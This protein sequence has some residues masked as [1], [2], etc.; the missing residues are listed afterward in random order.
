MGQGEYAAARVVRSH[1]HPDAW[2]SVFEDEL[3]VV[4]GL[5]R[6]PQRAAN[7]FAATA[8]ITNVGQA[9]HQSKEGMDALRLGSAHLVGHGQGKWLALELALQKS[10]RVK[11]LVLLDPQNT[12][13][14]MDAGA[15]L[16]ASG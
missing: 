13:A 9:S 11:S 8:N 1:A 4:E 7:A 6:T 3:P 12:F 14:R 5:G 16:K 2:S 15:L 10:D